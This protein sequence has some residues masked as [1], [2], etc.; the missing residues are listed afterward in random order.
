MKINGIVN[1]F[2]YEHHELFFIYFLNK[3]NN[4]NFKRKNGKDLVSD[5]FYY[6]ICS[7]STPLLKNIKNLP[8]NPLLFLRKP[9]ESNCVFH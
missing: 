8:P 2:C 5:F 1:V 9:L 4:S 6:L 3:Q 7:L